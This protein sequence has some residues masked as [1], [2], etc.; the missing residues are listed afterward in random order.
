MSEWPQAPLKQTEAP[1]I[2][3]DDVHRYGDVV[4]RFRQEFGPLSHFDGVTTGA[5]GAVEGLKRLKV[6]YDELTDKY[7]IAHAGF[8][9]FVG[10]SDGRT[11][12][13]VASR[14]IEG[15]ACPDPKDMPIPEHQRPAARLL[16][17]KLTEYTR[18]KH[19]NREEILSDI[20]GYQQYVFVPEAD[21][22]VLADTDPYAESEHGAFW[23]YERMRPWAAQV[24]EGEELA[25][26]H[27][28]MSRMSDESQQIGFDEEF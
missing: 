2:L 18:T 28:E 3:K 1:E 25:K 22:L 12:E 15:E 14:W 7:D 17:E 4:V 20:F 10:Q 26:W 27:A 13:F 21:L 9:P 23:A 24:L 8:V 16:F 6:L 19:N 11:G 5:T